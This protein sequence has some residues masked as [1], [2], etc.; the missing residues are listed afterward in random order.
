MCGGF[1]NK[2]KMRVVALTDPERKPPRD[3]KFTRKK[4]GGPVSRLARSIFFAEKK[5]RSRVKLFV[6]FLFFN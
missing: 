1:I 6:I 3:R 5:K 4:N 2:T